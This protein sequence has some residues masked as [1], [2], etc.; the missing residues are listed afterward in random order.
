MNSVSPLVGLGEP[1]GKVLDA[2]ENASPARAVE[3]VTR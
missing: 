1:F 3:A 2:A